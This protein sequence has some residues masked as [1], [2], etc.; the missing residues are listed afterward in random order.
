MDKVLKLI[1]IYFSILGN[2]SH[3]TELNIP[4]QKS[5]IS[6]DPT[7]I[8]DV[9]SLFVSRQINCQLVRSQGAILN[10]EAAE[11]I[12]YISPLTIRVKIKKNIFFH[13][14]S[15]VT[16][17]DV[18]ASFNHLKKSRTVMRNIFSW[19]EKIKVI[20]NHTI[21]F[22]LKKPI[23]QFL[24]VLSSPN[25]AIYKKS[26]LAKAEKNSN[27]WNNPLGCGGYRIVSKKSKIIKLLPVKNGIPITFH[28]LDNNLINVDEMERYDL[29]SLH[30]VGLSNKIKKFKKLELFDP[31]QLYLGLNAKS[32]LWKDKKQRCAFLSRIN[33]NNILKRYGN[34]ATKANDFLPQGCLGY[35]SSNQFM[36]KMLK[37]NNKEKILSQSTTFN[38][39]YLTVSIPQ[40]YLQYYQN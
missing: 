5:L 25:Y 40:I 12:K 10:L 15:S 14:K 23:P 17:D 26:F 39:A 24:T 1:I 22:S 37:E 38:L 16:S 13:D 31:L 33:P 4:L 6:L 8:Q 20:D 19:I 34:S 3:S 29:V 28:I 2:V 30:V 21:I 27:L 36:K 7:H 9:P 35:E 32:N 11:E 18:I